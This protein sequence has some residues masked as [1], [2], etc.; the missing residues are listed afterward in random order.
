MDPLV[1][2][3][4][5]HHLAYQELTPLFVFNVS[6]QSERL[7]YGVVDITVEMQYSEN[8]AANTKVYAL[9]ISDIR[10]KLQSDGK[11]MNVLY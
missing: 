6:K 8:V 7:N 2:G 10:L 4:M 11:R 5:I 3:S 1:S 9:V